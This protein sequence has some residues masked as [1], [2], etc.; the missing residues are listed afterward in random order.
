MAKEKC[1]I[2]IDKVPAKVLQPLGIMK[3]DGPA[4]KV[5]MGNEYL[6]TESL[7]KAK[8]YAKGHAT[9]YPSCKL[10]KKI[11]SVKK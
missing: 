11:G 9:A 1:F 8:W 2:K 10:R 5:T 4:Y 7:S 6:Y 3:F